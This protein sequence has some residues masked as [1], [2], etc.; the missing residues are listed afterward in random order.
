MSEARLDFKMRYYQAF[1]TYLK[2]LKRTGKHIIICGDVNTA[3]QEIDLYHPKENSKN[4]GFLPQERAWLDEL[5]AAGFIDSFREI[6][7][8]TNQYT[9]WDVRTGARARNIGWRID[10][11]FINKE[12]KKLLKNATIMPEVMG[13]DH[14]PITISVDL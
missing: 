10:Y 4:S 7:H 8:D 3:H 11:F 6:N 2:N 9:W 12:A 1:L 14:C 13:S 5:F